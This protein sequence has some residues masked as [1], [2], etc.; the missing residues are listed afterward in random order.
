VEE[1][2]NCILNERHENDL[3]VMICKGQAYGNAS[4]MSGIHSAAQRRIKDI[5][6]KAIFVPCR[7]HSLI[8]AGVH[9]VG[10]FEFSDIFSLLFHEMWYYSFVKLILMHVAL[11]KKSVGLNRLKCTYC[12]DILLSSAYITCIWI[13]ALWATFIKII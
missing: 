1:I 3:D 6:S 12:N 11:C 8:L 5:N 2:T 4:T 13:F 7:N 10:S 9:A